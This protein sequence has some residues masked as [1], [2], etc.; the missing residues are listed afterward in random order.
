MSFWNELTQ[1]FSGKP[2]MPRPVP[3]NIRKQIRR[4]S[5]WLEAKH[6]SDFLKDNFGN[7]PKTPILK[8]PPSELIGPEYLVNTFAYYIPTHQITESIFPSI[9]KSQSEILVGTIRYRLW[10]RSHPVPSD[11]ELVNIPDTCQNLFTVDCFCVDRR[12]RTKGRKIGTW[13]LKHLHYFANTNAIPYA[14]FMKEGRPL[15]IPVW[16]FRSGIY[17]WT[18]ADYAA[19]SHSFPIKQL[20]E[21]RALAWLQ[22]YY[23]LQMSMSSNNEILSNQMLKSNNNPRLYPMTHNIYNSRW[24]LYRDS[25][26]LWILI[27]VENTNQEHNKG[28]KIGYFT[29]IYVSHMFNSDKNGLSKLLKDIA[30]YI[31]KIMGFSWIWLDNNYVIADN[32][33]AETDA[34]VEAKTSIELADWT[35]D[36]PHY[37][38]AFQW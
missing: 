36:G 7:P 34:K 12:F 16:P 14:V 5:T 27:R 3:E 23:N 15:T 11:T 17:A 33:L 25:I 28:G 1:G 2:V 38:Y 8:V 22:N 20:T 24:Y 13:L 21:G 6:V 4:V 32:P 26:S 29:D 30:N 10:A 19:T 9:N 31:S 18:K 37:W 35:T